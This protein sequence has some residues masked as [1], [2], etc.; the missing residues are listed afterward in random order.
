M[1]NKKF[2]K[3]SPHIESSLILK[4]TLFLRLKHLNKFKFLYFES[5]WNSVLTAEVR[6]A[7]PK[8]QA[9]FERIN[10]RL[11][12]MVLKNEEFLKTMG[13][14][15]WACSAIPWKRSRMS[16]WCRAILNGWI[17][18]LSI[19][20]ERKMGFGRHFTEWVNGWRVLKQF[21]SIRA[22]PH[23]T[24][25][26]C[27]KTRWWQIYLSVSALPCQLGF[28]RLGA[29][30]QWNQTAW[31]TL[32]TPRLPT[33]SKLF[34]DRTNSTH[35]YWHW[36]YALFPVR[37]LAGTAQWQRKPEIRAILAW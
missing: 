16:L 37:V 13:I 21:C 33:A 15:W 1:I 34:N 9:S 12:S 36:A 29:S 14:A 5:T 3:S 23:R 18:S 4:R 28:K 35:A 19:W 22:H 7:L 25:R 6:E 2:Q 31:T 17:S 11:E 27:R 10:A 30:I 24:A 20:I 26:S 32:T 8:M